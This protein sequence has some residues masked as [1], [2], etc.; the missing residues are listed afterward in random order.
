MGDWMRVGNDNVEMPTGRAFEVQAQKIGG[1]D[2]NE[3]VNPQGGVWT[4]R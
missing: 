4:N 1:Y 3:N 2:V